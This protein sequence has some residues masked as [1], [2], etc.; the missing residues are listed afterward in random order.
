MSRR[1]A[2][3]RRRSRRLG[4]PECSSPRVGVPSAE[5]AGGELPRV[6]CEEGTGRLGCAGPL[7]C[8]GQRLQRNRAELV[9]QEAAHGDSRYAGGAG[10]AQDRIRLRC[11]ECTCSYCGSSIDPAEVVL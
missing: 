3:P 10:V 11:A 4:S 2:L 9:D 1:F 8:A 7:G 6:P 5:R